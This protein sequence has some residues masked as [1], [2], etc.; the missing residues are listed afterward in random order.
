MELWHP[1]QEVSSL[2]NVIKV[3]NIFP[4]EQRPDSDALMAEVEVF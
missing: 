4:E 3:V 2:Q 1:A